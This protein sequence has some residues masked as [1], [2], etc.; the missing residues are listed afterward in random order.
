M[1]AQVLSARYGLI[2]A[3]KSIRWYDQELSPNRRNKLDDLVERQVDALRADRFNDIYVDAGRRYLPL[4]DHLLAGEGAK[5][6]LVVAT[7]APGARS[8]KL[9]N[10]LYG[11]GHVPASQLNPHRSLVVAG[12]SITVSGADLISRARRM[13][14]DAGLESRDFH[15]WCAAIDRRRVSAKWLVSLATGLP[16]SKFSSHTAVRVLRRLGVPVAPA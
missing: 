14:P 2:S 1:N 8:A 6:P 12:V 11:V 9:L 16:V 5:T 10:W 4:I 3:R 7:G 15:S 13:L